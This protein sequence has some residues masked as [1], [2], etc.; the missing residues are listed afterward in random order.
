MCKDKVVSFSRVCKELKQA[1]HFFLLSF[2]GEAIFRSLKKIRA[3]VFWSQQG[4][5]EKMAVLL[6]LPTKKGL[7]RESEEANTSK[8]GKVVV[9]SCVLK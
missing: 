4:C 1:S 6:T 3:E 9:D 8:P 5:V 2:N 7:R